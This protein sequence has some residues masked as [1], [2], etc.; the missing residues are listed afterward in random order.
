MNSAL[1]KISNNIRLNNL[2]I[3]FISYDE[4]N[5]EI[6]W[7]HLQEIT[8]NKAKRVHGV[9]GFDK[10]H[11]LC[12]KAS[13]TQRLVIID[14]DSWVNS[15]VLDFELNDIDHK[16]ACFSFKSINA[17]NGLEYGN[18]GIKVWDKQTLLNSKTHELSS[19]TDFCWDIQYY[20]ID[21]ISGTTVQNNSPYQAWRAGY[22]EG[23]KMTYLNGKPPTDW[24]TDRKKIWKGNLSKLSIWCTVGR[25]IENGIW[26][27]LGARQGLFEILSHDIDSTYIND[28]DWFLSKWESIKDSDVDILLMQYASKLNTL[29]EFYVPELDID[30]SKWFKR[31]YINP[32]RHGLMK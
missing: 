12:A 19:T 28:Y 4:P 27:M 18:G 25:D 15:N 30:L 7:T 5:A 8:N 21:H 11:K 16:T 2:D 3:F 29:Y 32:A 14:G 10:V 6:N 31:T 9:K 17:I 23:V 22:R 13:T 20:Q 1:D 24:N 26:A